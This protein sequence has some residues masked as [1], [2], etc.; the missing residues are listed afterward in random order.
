MKYINLAFFV[1]GLFL[2]IMFC[3]INS[4]YKFDINLNPFYAHQHNLSSQIHVFNIWKIYFNTLLVSIILYS[5]L[6]LTNFITI[7]IREK[8]ERN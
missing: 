7:L 2:F 6:S 5:L 4:Y 1:V 8:R 3:V